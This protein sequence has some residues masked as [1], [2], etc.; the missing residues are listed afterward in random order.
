M[1][2]RIASLALS[3]AFIFLI[4][5][6][7]MLNS[8][9]LFYMG[10]A[11]LATLGA[12]RLQ[13][14][15]SV[16]ALR[17][18]RFA[19]AS[20]S[21]GE[22]VTVELEVSSERRIRRPLILV[23]DHI[24][25]RLITADM[26]SSLPVAPAFDIPI[27][28]RYHFRPMRRGKFRWTEVTVVGTDALG[29]VTQEHVYRLEPHELT[30]LPAPIALD[31]VL[32]PAVGWGAAEAEHGMA[33]GAGIEPRG[34]REYVAG[35]PLR[36][37]HWRS[38]ARAGQLL[39]KEFETG[40]HASVAFFVQR[41]RGSDVGEG[42]ETTLEQMCGNV[43]Y[44]SERLLRSGT[45][46]DMPALDVTGPAR[47]VHD[48]RSDILEALAAVEAEGERPISA[49]LVDATFVMSPGSVV[50]VLVSMQ[51]PQLPDAVTALS[52]R[53]FSVMALLY[54]AHDF[55]PKTKQA[56]AADA[57]YALALQEAGARV[58]RV[59]KLGVAK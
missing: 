58:V 15:L 40:S 9:A 11:L 16:R 26:S 36:F 18:H 24:P 48:R 50:Y 28:T 21:L 29:L 6:A 22:T 57:E 7:I 31:V 49:E 59:P 53:G 19:P 45:Q 41:S 35:D 39:V 51:D 33:R 52:L 23:R 38:S 46:V 27:R 4:V 20:A 5:V 37:V 12:A 25:S 55:D 56:S 44:L 8:G 17:L 43:A 42:V 34:I 54:D 47:S 32:P 10:T 3:T 13:A 30:V 14:W 2:S 1:T